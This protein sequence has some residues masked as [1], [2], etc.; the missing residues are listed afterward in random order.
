MKPVFRLRLH[1][2]GSKLTDPNDLQGLFLEG[3]ETFSG[4]ESHNK[5]QTLS[6]QSCSLHTILL[7]TKLT[8]M[9][10][11]MPI[12]CFLFEIQ[13]TKSGFTGSISYPVFRE[14]GPWSENRIGWAFCLQG[15]VLEPAR[16]GFKGPGKYRPKR[17]HVNR[18][19]AGPVRFATVPVQGPVSRRCRKV[20]GPGKP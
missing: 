9:Q 18:T 16:E 3:S 2:T 10:S 5:N 19:R 17:F 13:I 6:L 7:Q 14:T 1:E 15:T 4:P 11:L 8:S 20:F 12:H